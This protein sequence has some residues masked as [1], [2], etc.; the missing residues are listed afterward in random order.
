[1]TSLSKAAADLGRRGGQ[2]RSDTKAKSA[3]KNGSRGGR[4]RRFKSTV[5]AADFA[6]QAGR[7]VIGILPSGKRIRVDAKGTLVEFR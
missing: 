1:M 4:P 2:V 3:R 5:E 7:T 6:R